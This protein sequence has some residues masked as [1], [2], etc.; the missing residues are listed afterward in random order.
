MDIYDF[1]KEELVEA[2]AL[3]SQ[4]IKTSKPNHSIFKLLLL[5]MI[6]TYAD[7]NNYRT[8]SQSYEEIA[9][10]CGD[11][12]LAINKQRKTVKSLKEIASSYSSRNDYI[13]DIIAKRVNEYR[14][15][16]KHQ[17]TSFKPMYNTR[18]GDQLAEVENILQ[19]YDSDSLR[20]KQ[21]KLSSYTNGIT[22]ELLTDRLSGVLSQSEKTIITSAV[23]TISNIK[24][25]IEHAKEKKKRNERSRELE[26]IQ[27]SRECLEAVTHVFNIKSLLLPELVNF[28]FHLCLNTPNPT[29]VFHMGNFCED[30]NNCTV[31]SIGRFARKLNDDITKFG[32]TLTEVCWKYDSHNKY[33]EMV[34]PVELLQSFYDDWVNNHKSTI[35]I[36]QQQYL[37]HISSISSEKSSS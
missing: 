17:F 21:R 30:I 20:A 19:Y 9:T 4:I 3:L 36:K 35:M 14:S 22:K 28:G 13:Q 8:P 26:E 23:T 32:V 27:C 18:F 15:V 10:L 24:H 5:G 33:K 7:E 1:E 2:Q 31:K 37:Q 34:D 29:Y 12:L 25:T 6:D 16:G 11:R